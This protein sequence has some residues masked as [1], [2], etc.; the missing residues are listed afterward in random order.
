MKKLITPQLP[1]VVWFLL[2]LITP[3][4]G[5]T[6]TLENEL[7]SAAQSLDTGLRSG[8]TSLVSWVKGELGRKPGPTAHLDPALGKNV[9]YDSLYHI[10]QKPHVTPSECGIGDWVVYG[11]H[12]HHTGN[13]W[14]S[15]NFKLLSHLAFFAYNIDCETGGPAN[16]TGSRQAIEVW[17][18]P[19]TTQLIK[20]AHSEG[21]RV[22]LT[23]TLNG[24]GYPC[25]HNPHSFLENESAVDHCVK[26]VSDMLLTNNADGVCVDIEDMSVHGHDSTLFRRFIKKLHKGIKKAN[27]DATLTIASPALYPQDYFN[28]PGLDP[29]V[30]YYVIMG[31]DF[32]WSGGPTAGPI[33]PLPGYSGLD[34]G[35][36]VGYYVDHGVPKEKLV[37]AYPY[38]G[39]KW[40]TLSLEE[41]TRNVVTSGGKPEAAKAVTYSNF[42]NDYK[43]K[44]PRQWESGPKSSW[45]PIQ[46]GEK[47]EQLW[48]PDSIA[49]ALRFQ[50]VKDKGLAGTGM[51]ALGYDNG[52]HTFWDLLHAE[53]ADCETRAPRTDKHGAIVKP[54]QPSSKQKPTRKSP[55]AIP[56]AVV[57]GGVM[58]AVMLVLGIRWGRRLEREKN[59]GPW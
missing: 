51:W 3:F 1:S 4:M 13:S 20:K 35:N 41:G 15:Y 48:L 58:T 24:S 14:L 39:Y 56:V 18:S 17:N 2:L 29:Y 30:S 37:M 26:Q 45:F 55:F 31:Y 40:P 36:S 12:R 10:V 6:Q 32:H 5:S 47:K 34:L 46:A 9:N 33:S 28:L 52:Y 8:E 16:T 57:I 59:S 21:C 43:G 22:D 42:R 53:F 27:P 23:L 25:Y 54:P 19:G 49:M 50:F 7:D 11:F 38:Y 44:Y